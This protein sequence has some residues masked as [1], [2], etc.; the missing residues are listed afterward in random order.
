MNL[1]T[2][3]IIAGVLL[4]SLMVGVISG[5]LYLTPS[6]F[7]ASPIYWFG[8]GVYTLV[9]GLFVTKSNRTWRYFGGG[10]MV[11]GLAL[12]TV[13]QRYPPVL[14]FVFGFPGL[15]VGMSLRAAYVFLI[16]GR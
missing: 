6:A 13:S 1:R 5:E 3:R 15:F 9:G 10:V 14:T 4:A 12:L 16:R 2:N 8:L 7:F 11:T